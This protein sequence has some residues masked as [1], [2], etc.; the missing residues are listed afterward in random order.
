[1]GM[2]QPQLP[3]EFRPVPYPRD[4][5]QAEKLLHQGAIATDDAP[6]MWCLARLLVQRAISTKSVDDGQKGALWAERAGKAGVPDALARVARIYLGGSDGA[7]PVPGV[8]TDYQKAKTLAEQALKSGSG[9]T[10]ALKKIVQD[11]ERGLASSSPSSGGRRR[12]Q[13]ARTSR[14]DLGVSRRN[15]SPRSCKNIKP[16][17]KE[18]GLPAGC[19]VVPWTTTTR[20]PARRKARQRTENVEDFAER[21]AAGEAPDRGR[22]AKGGDWQRREEA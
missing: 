17:R 14:R 19:P 6:T 11:A 7:E 1:M 15:P 2:A 12:Q 9:L 18:A 4:V 3:G 10:D 21:H 5:D 22:P 16:R 20:P 13:E 8:K